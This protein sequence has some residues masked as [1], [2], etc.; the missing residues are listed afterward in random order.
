M[1]FKCQQTG[2]CCVARGNIGFVFLT[3]KDIDRL[4]LHTGIPADQLAKRSR[5]EYTR[6]SKAPVEAWHLSKS[7]DQCRFLKGKQCSVYEAR[8]TQCRTY[9]YWPENMNAE[10]WAEEGKFCAGIGKGDSKAGDAK[11]VEQIL[12]DEEY[13]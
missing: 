4:V 13:A 12:A 9:P 3:K 2:R 7:E 8:P 6:F 11:L 5:F 10:R 1:N